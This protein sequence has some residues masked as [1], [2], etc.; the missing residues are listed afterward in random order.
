MSLT[1]GRE[2]LSPALGRLDDIRAQLPGDLAA[3]LAAS[4]MMRD[5]RTIIDSPGNH[6]DDTAVPSEY[7]LP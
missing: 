6:L 7:G 4:K 3:E 2:A 5:A 1:G